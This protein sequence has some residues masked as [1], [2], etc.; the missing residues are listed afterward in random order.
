MG[1]SVHVFSETRK[2]TRAIGLRRRA[3]EP[4]AVW[5]LAILGVA[6]VLPSLIAAT[7]A[8]A[9][10]IGGELVDEAT[11]KPLAGAFV[12]L[13]DADSTE[14][15]RTLTNRYGQFTVNV[16]A[17]GRYRLKSLV[18]G[19]RSFI[20]DPIVV[21][22]GELVSFRFEIPATLVN[23]PAVVVEDKRIC[24][25]RPAAGLAAAVLW[26]EIKKAL[27][28]VAWTE[29]QAV[30]QH[31]LIM[32]ER[33]LERRSLRTRS[34]KTWLE[35]G[36]YGGSPFATLPPEQLADSG[37]IQPTG[38]DEFYF[39][40]PDAT[41]LLSDEFAYGHCFTVRTDVQSETPQ[42]GLAFSPL[43]GHRIPDIEGVLWVDQQSA[44]LQYLEFRYTRL[45][46]DV[47][48]A[49]I[50]GRVEFERLPSGPWIVSKWWIRMPL[51]SIRFRPS[52]RYSLMVEEYLAAICESGGWV[53]G[54]STLSGQPVAR[55]DPGT[56]IGTV[57]DGHERPLAGAKLTLVG[58]DFDAVSDRAGRFRFDSLPP[59]TYL[60]TLHSETSD[61]MAFVAPP[62]EVTIV[63][64]DTTV[65]QLPL[66]EKSAVW[67]RLCPDVEPEEKVGL[68]AGFVTDSMTG[69]P[70][71]DAHV[72]IRGSQ[73][74]AKVFPPEIRVEEDSI[75]LEAVT[76]Y[77]GY[78][79]LCGVPAELTLKI[80]PTLGDRV[81]TA[82]DV[83]LEKSEMMRV[84]L[85][86]GR[87]RQPSG[88]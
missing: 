41:V 16:P 21:D 50:G 81:G 36:V 82:S 52:I 18:I 34:D 53:M 69:K 60:L 57:T 14:R 83:K 22:A 35:G 58:T 40:G 9:Q 32:Y 33:E 68:V 55:G 38:S 61:T 59:S 74:T 1:V 75:L 43:P 76:D 13:L 11:G 47:E 31:R 67:D 7:A 10:A 84:D 85:N 56:L 70:L 72:T 78:Y 30:L 66:P 27:D 17:P 51:V 79:H 2:V 80:K 44:E 20:S 24:R 4:C 86:I 45:P 65:S 49:R 87:K 3:P 73:W 71:A 29:Q 46:W 64:R 63:S 37:Y 42:I 77:T 15:A 25:T 26:E 39:Y 28:A 54:V 6:V 48:S 5:H 88:N 8:R 12:V 62:I 23:L 19:S